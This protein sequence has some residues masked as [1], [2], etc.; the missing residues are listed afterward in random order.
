MMIGQSRIAIKH[1]HFKDI[2]MLIKSIN[3]R[4]D[5][6]EITADFMNLGYSKSYLVK[7]GYEF[8]LKK[9]SINN[10]LWTKE[11]LVCYRKASWKDLTQDILDAL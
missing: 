11:D 7:D 10:W 5:H 8:K 1:K 4:H 2:F 3:Q 6:Y 9:D